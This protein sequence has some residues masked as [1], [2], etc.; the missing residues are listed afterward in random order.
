MEWNDVVDILTV[1]TMADRRTTGELD[2]QWWLV[3]A[4]YGQWPSKDF[5]IAA[6]I[7]HAAER[8]DVWLN[9]GH[10]TC[11]WNDVRREANRSFVPPVPSLDV[12][13]DPKANHEAIEQARLQHQQRAVE[14]FIQPM[15]E[16]IDRTHRMIT[17]RR[18][19]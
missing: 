17:A 10:I 9:P 11:I 18:S 2:V 5:A 19:R 7:K 6:V 8:P 3:Q 16:H 13:N 12:L 4:N 15:R 14:E 1:V